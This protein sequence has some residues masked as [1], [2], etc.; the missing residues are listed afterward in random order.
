M[1]C[2]LG[3]MM[4]VLG[5]PLSHNLM[6]LL[7]SADVIVSYINISNSLTRYYVELTGLGFGKLDQKLP[8]I[9][10]CF[11]NKR[12][13]TDVIVSYINISNSLTRYYV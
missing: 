10:I 12:I 7:F 2:Q 1:T 6:V 3:K 13:L 5:P 11:P 4:F 9:S 8:D